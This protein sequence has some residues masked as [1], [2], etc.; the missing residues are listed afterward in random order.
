[1]SQVSGRQ[2]IFALSSGKLP[3]GVA[4]IRLSGPNASAVVSQLCGVLPVPRRATLNKLVAADGRVMDE[5]L[6]LWFPA[7]HSFTGEDCAEFQSHGGSAVVAALLREL[8]SIEGCRLADA[9]EFSLRA[10]TNGKADL[11][12]MESLADLIDAQTESQRALAIAGAT[13]AFRALYEG[14]RTELLKARA[15]LEADLDF[16]DEDDVPGSV[17]SAANAVVGNLIDELEAYLKTARIGEIIRE[18]FRVVIAGAPNVGKS[19]LLNTLAKRDVAIVTDIAGTTRDVLDVYLDLGGIK[20]VVSDTAGLRETS[21]RVEQIGIDRAHIAIETADL[22]LMLSETSPDKIE[23]KAPVWH[24]K[25]KNDEG[26]VL[27]EEFDHA[28]SCKTGAGINEL[29]AAIGNAARR[30]V[31]GVLEGEVVS[32]TRHVAL[33]ESALDALFRFTNAGNKGVEFAAEELR[34]AADSIGRIT[35]VIST[36]D[37]LGQVFSSFC[38]GK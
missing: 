4:V 33:L 18:G 34:I 7:P 22:V 13:G 17:A 35:G 16:S 11:T 9:G 12:Q 1:M 14:W 31:G 25:T 26:A 10:F 3:S 37:V 6:V 19:T 8:G 32:R 30:A 28:I 21:D 36:E 23:I 15:Y 29:I 2:T 5:G 20:V 24:V 38:I 27:E